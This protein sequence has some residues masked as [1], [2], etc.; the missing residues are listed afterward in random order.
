MLAA[1]E[2]ALLSMLIFEPPTNAMKTISSGVEQHPGFG[3]ALFICL[4]FELYYVIRTRFHRFL[5]WL[6]MASALGILFYPPRFTEAHLL[7]ACCLLLAIT[8]LVNN[9]WTWCALA[10]VLVAF[11]FDYLGPAEVLFAIVARST[12]PC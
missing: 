6:A 1:L 4:V 2:A 12:W 10:V 11:F 8:G 5:A 3:T 7:Y 9:A